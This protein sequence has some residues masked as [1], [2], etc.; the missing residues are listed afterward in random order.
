MKFFLFRPPRLITLYVAIF[1][2]RIILAPQYCVAGNYVASAHGD[3][4]NGVQR[5]GLTTYSPGNCAHCHEQ[6]ASIGG[7]EIPPNSP[8]GPDIYLG[9]ETEDD[10]CF[11]C[12]GTTPVG[13]A[14]DIA[15]D[16]TTT[17][18]FGHLVQNYSGIHKAN[19]SQSD[20]ADTKHIECTDCHNPH[21][22]GNTPHTPAAD[23]VTSELSATS[24]LFGVSGVDPDYANN[25]ANIWDAPGQG[26]YDPVKPATKEYQICFKCHS[27]AV[28]NPAS[29]SDTTSPTYTAWTDVGLEFNPYNKSGHP[30]V[31]GLNNYPNSI[32]GNNG[33]NANKIKK[34]LTAAQMSAPWD[35]NVGEQTMYC[36]D[37]HGSNSSVAGPHGSAIKWMLAGPRRAWP[38]LLASNNGTNLQDQWTN[39]YGDARYFFPKDK[40]WRLGDVSTSPS[41]TNGL[42]CLNCHPVSGTNK[43]HSDSHHNTDARCADCH[44]RVPHGSKVSR[45]IAAVDADKFDGTNPGPLY[46]IGLPARYTA[47]GDGHAA[48]K[49]IATDLY[50]DNVPMIRQFTKC[51][52]GDYSR[53]N[54]YSTSLFDPNGYS[55]YT[56]NYGHPNP[57]KDGTTGSWSNPLLSPESW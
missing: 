29:W 40:F 26:N 35:I 10:L 28:G 12:H 42:F 51:T 20:I 44:I 2:C 43:V 17:D 33:Y 1:A 34:G 48:G 36:S 5:P 19:E 13:T 25:A 16:I 54:C 53:A 41:D 38:Y 52:P 7:S 24:P 3:G 15:T 56:C 50:D 23:T 47:T 45:L 30:V 49:F 14:P 4:I 37:C 6:H 31:T 55:S 22:A 8:A 18:H 9:A 57:A 39:P 27:K 32:S 21:N 46:D 11:I